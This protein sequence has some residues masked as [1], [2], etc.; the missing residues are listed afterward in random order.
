V[1]VGFGILVIETKEEYRTL[2]ENLSALRHTT[3]YNHKTSMRES[4]GL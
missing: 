3:L 2:R 1:I 4:I